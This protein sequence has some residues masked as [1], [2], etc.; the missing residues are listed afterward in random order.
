MLIAEEFF[1]LAHDERT[2]KAKT[3]SL[4]MRAAIPGALLVELVVRERIAIAPHDLGWRERDKVTVLLD[5]TTEDRILDEALL[6]VQKR[7]GKSANSIV[8]RWA[9]GKTGKHFIDLVAGRLVAAGILGQ[10]RHKALGIFPVAHYP[11]RDP[12]PEAEVRAPRQCGSPGRLDGS[13]DG[14]PDRDAAGHADLD[15]GAFSGDR[16]Q[17]RQA[18]GEADRQA[19]DHQHRG[20][21]GD[22]AGHRVGRGERCGCR[23]GVIHACRLPRQSAA[24]LCA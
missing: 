14:H 6:E 19:G 10:E 15:H 8:Q 12:G 24:A 22:R 7:A 1:L 9:N 4:Q 11:E 3:G 21:G 17:G 23:R 20:Q 5:R 13:A 18:G 16:S 2:G